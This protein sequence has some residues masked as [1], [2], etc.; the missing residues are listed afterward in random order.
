[1]NFPVVA[2]RFD[3]FLAEVRKIR[4]LSAEREFELAVRYQE[5]GDVEAAHELVVS[6][7]PFVVKI[8]FQYKNYNLPLPDM[9]QEGSI[10]LMKS[11]KRF[12]PYKGYRLASFAV[13]WIKAYVKNFIIKSWNL[14]KLGTTQAQRRLFF[15]IGDIGEHADA[16]SKAAR[17]KELAED[18][19]V[20]E[21]DV[22]EMVA[23][24][25]AREYSLSDT[26]G[27]DGTLTAIDLIEDE[28][29]DQ[30]ALL[31]ERET[32]TALSDF[33]E[34]ALTKLNDRE[35]FIITKRY[36]DDEPWTLQQLGDHYGTSRERMRQI[37]KRALGK[38]RKELA[39]H[40]IAGL[41]PEPIAA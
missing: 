2:D 15:R 33:T 28:T 23:R 26:V 18:L 40:P 6:H 3:Y 30:Q 41:L 14:V 22:I 25:K 32:E 8:A 39:A 34:K 9:V 20:K 38:L 17:V 35:R 27:E 29:P 37:E 11:V 4:P 19:K 7:L 10:G 31:E 13:W 12:D 5:E 36:F 21:D 24:M 16:E 1:M